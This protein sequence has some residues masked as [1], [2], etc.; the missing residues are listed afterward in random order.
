VIHEGRVCEG[1]CAHQQITEGHTRWHACIS[2]ICNLTSTRSM[3]VRDRNSG[4]LGAGVRTSSG[5]SASAP[6]IA[7]APSPS[8]NRL[9]RRGPSGRSRVI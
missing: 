6:R 4:L 7:A 8:S 2:R 5:T 1:R 3:G 9:Y